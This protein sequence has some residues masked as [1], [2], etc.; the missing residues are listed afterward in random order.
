MKDMGASGKLWHLYRMGGITPV[1]ASLFNSQNAQQIAFIRSVM[2][3]QRKESLLRM[4][5]KSLNGVVFDL[6]TTGFSPYGG[7][8]ILSIGAV[9]VE[10][11]RV[12]EQETFYTLVKPKKRIPEEVKE[13]TGINDD[14]GKEA[15]ELLEGLRNFLHFVNSRVL[16]AHGTGHD[17][18]FLDSALWRTSR[19]HLRHPMLDTMMV[20]KWLN[21][22]IRDYSLDHLLDR[23]EIEIGRRHDALEDSL[24]TAQLWSKLSRQLQNIQIHT[25]GE[26]FERMSR[27]TQV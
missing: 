24:M 1:I 27:M 2:K 23:Y 11:E 19:T 12:N 16:L 13:L 4:K 15:P 22:D 9:A 3:D 10:G 20:A 5:L 17:K 18:R 25:I 21:P 26:L 7:D 14:M 8:E 6:E